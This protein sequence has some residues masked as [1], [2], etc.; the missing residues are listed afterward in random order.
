MNDEDSSQSVSEVQSGILESRALFI[1][2]SEFERLSYAFGAGVLEI[3]S[4][5]DHVTLLLP[6]V[7]E[8]EVRDHLKKAA[9][10]SVRAA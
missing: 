9:Q 7:I 3:L 5:Y 2:T 8:S 10:E 4:T 6:E 1:D